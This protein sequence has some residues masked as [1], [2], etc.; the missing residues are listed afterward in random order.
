MGVVFSVISHALH[1]SRLARGKFCVFCVISAM[2]IVDFNRLYYY[3]N[4]VRLFVRCLLEGLLSVP[5]VDRSQNCESDCRMH[6]F[7]SCVSHA[8]HAV[9]L[10][11]KLNRETMR[12]AVCPE[13]V[14]G[15]PKARKGRMGGASWVLLGA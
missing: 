2:L 13:I 6:S 11:K 4:R 10:L 5:G 8:F 1:E 14:A 15:P 7:L 12:V 9:Y 3:F